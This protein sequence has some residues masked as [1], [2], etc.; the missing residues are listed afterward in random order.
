[1]N[2]P[3]AASYDSTSQDL[4]VTGDTDDNEIT[5]W[6]HPAGSLLVNNG[7]VPV[8]GGTATTANTDLI[9]ASGDLG[10]DT[11]FIHSD[12]P[13]ELYGGGGDDA[14]TGGSGGAN[15]LAGEDGNDVLVSRGGA[16]SLHGGDG[17]D[18]LT[19]GIGDDIIDGG[20]GDDRMIW[21]SGDGHDIIEGGAG[22]ADVVEIHDLQ[23]SYTNT[24]FTVTAIGGRVQ[25]NQ[26]P[27]AILDIGTTESLVLS[28][29]DG[30]VRISAV[31]DLAGLI[32]LTI[33]AGIGDDQIFG[34]NGDDLIFGGPGDDEITGGAG[35]DTVFLGANNNIFFWYAGDGSDVVD[36]TSG[37]DTFRFHGDDEDEI[38]EVSR[39]GAHTFVTHDIGNAAVDLIDV[40]RIVIRPGAGED[41]VVFNPMAQSPVLIELLLSPGD[42]ILGG[43]GQVDTVTLMGSESADTISL[44]T[45][46]IGSPVRG[47][48]V[49]GLPNNVLVWDPDAS[50][51]LVVRAGG[52]TTTSCPSPTP[53]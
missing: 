36:G 10:A 53:R 6:H 27:S 16:D 7:A 33:D 43:D 12:L 19:G 49:Q 28:T 50:D 40:E 42:G 24:V 25:V 51:R 17:D 4:T 20:D 5:V 9:V 31:G 48:A 47:V 23:P 2:V 39:N 37:R 35:D 18:T 32:N 13:V 30:D 3:I 45:S 14:L 41:S 26:G 52:G 15:I 29:G 22:L 38:I 46:Y 8:T 34:G 21:E 1:M 44:A 11:I